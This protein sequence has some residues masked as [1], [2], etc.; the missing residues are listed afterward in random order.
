MALTL[1][2]LLSRPLPV[3]SGIGS[4]TG[5]RAHWQSSHHYQSPAQ[6]LPKPTLIFWLDAVTGIVA[7]LIAV[8]IRNLTGVTLLLFLS[9]VDSVVASSRGFLWFPSVFL[10]AFKPFLLVLLF[11]RLRWVVTWRNWFWILDF[12][13]LRVGKI[14]GNCS[15]GL[16][17]WSGVVRWAMTLGATDIQVSD[18]NGRS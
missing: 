8:E 9:G 16:H 12:K 3:F 13:F 2:P 5:C 10:S 6:R 1:L 17:L 4:G 14:F 11:S 7:F 15:L 18:H